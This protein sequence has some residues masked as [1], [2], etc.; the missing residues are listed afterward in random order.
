MLI[1]VTLLLCNV[2]ALSTDGPSWVLA[3]VDVIAGAAVA[4]VHFIW[5]RFTEQGQEERLLAQGLTAGEQPGKRK[6]MSRAFVYAAVATGS[7]LI[8]FLRFPQS[9][10]RGWSGFGYFESFVRRRVRIPCIPRAPQ[11]TS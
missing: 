10:I 1:A 7:L 8:G 11:R 4:L 9:R 6:L 2:A 3:V 5:S